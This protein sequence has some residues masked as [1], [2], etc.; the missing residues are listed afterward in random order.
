MKL[1]PCLHKGYQSP[2]IIQ[3]QFINHS[4]YSFS[5]INGSDI[6]SCAERT[7]VQADPVFFG[8]VNMIAT[9]FLNVCVYVR[10]PAM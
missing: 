1:K 4:Y 8:K 9:L 7:S 3:F 2:F 5:F 6:H 10:E